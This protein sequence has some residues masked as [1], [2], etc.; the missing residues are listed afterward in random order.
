[1]IISTFDDDKPKVSFLPENPKLSFLLSCLRR[2]WY[3]FPLH[4]LIP[5]PSGAFR[6]SCGGGT[7]CLGLGK[8]PIG[9][10]SKPWDPKNPQTEKRLV[11]YLEKWHDRGFGIHLGLSGLVCLDVDPR[12]GG[13]ESLARLQ[14][15]GLV[16]SIEP[17]VI[18]GGGGRHLYFTAPA[19]VHDR[20]G[21]FGPNRQRRCHVELSPGIDWLS[22]QHFMVLP[23]SPHKSGGAH[24][25]ARPIDLLEVPAALSSLVDQQPAFAARQGAASAVPWVATGAARLPGAESRANALAYIMTMEPAVSGHHGSRQTG[26]A[27]AICLVDFGLSRADAKAVLV[28]WNMGCTP[29]WS[30]D[31]LERKL[32][33][34][35]SRPGTRGWRNNARPSNLTAD[36]EEFLRKSAKVPITW[37]KW[38]RGTAAIATVV[39]AAGLVALAAEIGCELCGV[40]PPID[41]VGSCDANE[42]AP[43]DT[44]PRCEHWRGIAFVSRRLSIGRIGYFPCRRLDCPG[45]FHV[46]KQH[47]I[48]TMRHHLYRWWLTHSKDECP[49]LFVADIP[50]TEW[51][52][53]GHRLTQLH[54]EY[55]R[56]DPGTMACI[57]GPHY[58]VVA[59]DQ[60]PGPRWRE[61]SPDEAAALLQEA[62]E[63]LPSGLRRP[64]W[65][66]S[67]GWK[68]LKEPEKEEEKWNRVGSIRARAGTT[69]RILDFHE[70]DRKPFFGCGQ[71]WPWWGTEFTFRPEQRDAIFRDLEA[72][73]T[74]G[75][76]V[77]FK[78]RQAIEEPAPEFMPDLPAGWS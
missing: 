68:L 53:V 72:G 59:T 63:G 11:A 69:E 52:E 19:N 3:I 66:S 42:S 75:A 46:K 35:E 25:L 31:E 26:R 20:L 41:A 54:A 17:H 44:V 5:E 22:G 64:V 61:I 71:R 18:T 38:R 29:Q 62:V 12:N 70:C 39:A 27:A 58:L 76:G 60:A 33:W 32:N 1:M 16:P 67:H 43:A 23:F 8:H 24:I 7:A 48:D 77:T 15:A 30:D 37:G 57:P 47:Y 14:S 21:W 51:N 49:P 9:R 2:G 56:L 50:R 45:C 10:W 13:N 40:T 6:C 65:W 34:A 4:L 74:L 36:E 55:F 28:E 78:R 73:D